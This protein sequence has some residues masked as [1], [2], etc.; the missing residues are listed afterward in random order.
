MRINSGFLRNQVHFFVK[1]RPK[2]FRFS[3]KVDTKGKYS[4]FLRIFGG[5]LGLFEG[6]SVFI[7]GLSFIDLLKCRTKLVPTDTSRPR[8]LSL[9]RIF[10]PKIGGEKADTIR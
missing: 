10:K 6:K 4:Q 2:L 9:S 5:I 3:Q 1:S 8:E 7:R